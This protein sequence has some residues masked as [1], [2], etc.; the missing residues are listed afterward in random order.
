MRGVAVSTPGKNLYPLGAY[1]LV[2]FYLMSSG[3]QSAQKKSSLGSHRKQLNL[4]LFQ[5]C[6]M[7]N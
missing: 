1:V 6:I 4:D 7:V 2:S 5:F 3:P